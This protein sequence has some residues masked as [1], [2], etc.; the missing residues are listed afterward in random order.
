MFTQSTFAL[1]LTT[2]IHP[3]LQLV[4]ISEPVLYTSSIPVITEIEYD[5]VI[6][7]EIDWKLIST[8][9]YPS[10]LVL[11]E[12]SAGYPFVH[13][14]RPHAKQLLMTKNNFDALIDGIHKFRNTEWILWTDTITLRSKSD[15]SKLINMCQR[16]TLDPIF[17]NITRVNKTF[18]LVKNQL[19]PNNLTIAFK[20]NDPTSLFIYPVTECVITD[21]KALV[22]L[23][24][25][26][27][28]QNASYELLK[29]QPVLFTHRCFF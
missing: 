13:V 4:K 11:D 26:V 24:I 3:G 14:T 27:H 16:R 18:E 6:S 21:T 17:W 25:P 9:V 28:T 22:A 8:K 19:K 7:S 5:T 10:H 20:P 29:L 23:K 15:F 1:D 12:P 2:M